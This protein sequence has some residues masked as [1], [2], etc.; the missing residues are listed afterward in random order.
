MRTTATC[1]STATK[2]ALAAHFEA[3]RSA[4]LRCARLCDSVRMGSTGRRSATAHL[5][6]RRSFL[7]TRPAFSARLNLFAP[8]PPCAATPPHG[9]L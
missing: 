4:R 3:A 8:R 5:T 2:C 1:S 6:A 9:D 7:S